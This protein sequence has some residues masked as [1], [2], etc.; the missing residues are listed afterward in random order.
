MQVC[1]CSTGFGSRA[2]DH[3]VWEA[4]A[5]AKVMITGPDDVVSVAAG[6]AADVIGD[7][8]VSVV[9]PADFALELRL[10]DMAAG[11][12][13]EWKDAHEDEVVYVC[14]GEIREGSRVCPQGG[15]IVLESGFS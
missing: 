14:A 8:R 13:V 15:A 10:L 7:V 1:R 2:I 11:A 3:S 4:P 9:T 5:M 6:A 12:A